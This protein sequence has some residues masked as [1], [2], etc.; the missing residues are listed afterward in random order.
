MMTG[1][2][3]VSKTSYRMSTLALKELQMQLEEFLKK[4]YIHPSVFPWG[5]L[6]FFVKKKDGTLKLCTDSNN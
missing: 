3:H 6:V 1:A 5:A 2:T 4:G